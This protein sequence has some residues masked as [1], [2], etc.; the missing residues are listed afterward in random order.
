MTTELKQN[1]V[2]GQWEEVPIPPKAPTNLRKSYF[3]DELDATAYHIALKLDNH[4][5]YARELS[6]VDFESYL[7][8]EE[9]MQARVTQL[10]NDGNVAHSAHELLKQQQGLALWVLQQ[11][12]VGWDLPRPFSNETLS[13]LNV[14]T[15]VQ[16]AT[17]ILSRTSLG[18]DADFLAASS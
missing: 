12:V 4:V 3:C 5:V 2:T 17:T 11:C 13:K 14:S 9:E 10:K 18:R 15:R 16:L 1:S 8:Q 6:D 7:K